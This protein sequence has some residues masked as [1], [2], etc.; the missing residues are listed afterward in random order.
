MREEKL[1]ANMAKWFAGDD[2]SVLLGSGPDDCAHL[3]ADGRR[4]AVSVDAF[5][6]GSHFLADADPRDIARKCLAASLSDLAASACRARWALVSLCLKKGLESSWAPAFAQ[7]LAAAS[8]EYGVTVVG[9]DTVAAPAGTFVAVTVIGEPL[10]GGPLLRSGARPGDVLAVTG[11][12]GGSIRGRHLRP[13]PRLRE[14]A[15]LMDRLYRTGNPA[16][17]P[18]AA[19][20]ISDGLALDLSRLC[21]ESGVGAEI[22]AAAV[23][24]AAAA[25]ELAVET[26]KTPLAHALTDGE[27]F[28]LLLA[29]PA[30]GWELF[31]ASG[32][33]T[34][35]PAGTD[36]GAPFT[37]IGRIVEGSEIALLGKDGRR[38]PLAPEGYEHQW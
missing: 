14:V 3:L 30:A 27:D 37:R 15:A 26:G 28:E 29:L 25:R 1:L 22:E 12:L 32:E 17:L 5:A 19:M 2:P 11:E 10:P 9:G 8:R 13:V 20:D 31:A 7:E 24:V 6:E 23:P 18:H 21:R 34:S 16:L 33:R 4:L 36:G 38:S 35:K